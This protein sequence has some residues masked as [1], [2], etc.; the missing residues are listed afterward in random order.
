M[1]WWSVVG[2]RSV[3]EALDIGLVVGSW[4]VVGGLSVN[5]DLSVVSGF[6]IHL[7]KESYN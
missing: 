5:G 4:W 3:G 7:S 2:C 1:G 6:A